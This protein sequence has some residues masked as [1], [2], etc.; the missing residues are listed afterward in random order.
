[1]KFSMKCCFQQSSTLPLRRLSKLHKMVVSTSSKTA[2][3]SLILF[4]IFFPL[5]AQEISFEENI[6]FSLW[7]STEA[8]PGIEEYQKDDLNALPVSKIKQTAPFILSGMVY[9]WNFDYT[10]YDKSRKV[11]EYFDFS[12]IQKLSDKEI[13][14]IRYKNP[15]I[16]NQKL[17][18]W[19]EFDRTESQ[20]M[21][22]NS[23]KSVN[24][25]NIK[26]IGYAPLSEGFEG[27]QKACGEALKN[28]VRSFERKHIKTKPKE[29]IGKALVSKPPVIGI[30]AGR[31]MVTLDFFMESDRILEYKTF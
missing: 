19:I 14:Q 3:F 15:W 8:I 1:M 12:E 11:Q 6:R 18:V 10:P 23:W 9:G 22:Y 4:Q 7:A 29:I 13:S 26:G 27:I 30:D 5:P 16:E 24:Y 21:L 28:A 25:R 2:I 20:Q 17:N 31:Y